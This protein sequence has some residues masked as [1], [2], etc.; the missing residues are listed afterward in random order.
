MGYNQA[1][2]AYHN[3]SIKTASQGRLVVMLYEAAVKNLKNAAGLFD[4]DGK[5]KTADIEKFGG[6][7]QKAQ[8]IITELQVS[9][10]M[11]RGGDISK[12]LMSLYVY[13]N[14]ELMGASIAH[15]RKKIEFVQN[16]LEELLAAWKSAANSTANAPAA[17]M[18]SALNIEG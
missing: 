11:E 10:D 18:Q 15:D 17:V 1:Y 6:L 4:L 5:I 12:N 13:F 14:S 8:S 7:I 16:M 2:T 3:A 9:L